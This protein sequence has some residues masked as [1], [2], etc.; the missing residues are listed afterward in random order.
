M[1]HKLR[2]AEQRDESAEERRSVSKSP[3]SGIS[4]SRL[5]EE[6][7]RVEELLTRKITNAVE[8]LGTLMKR[9]VKEQ[10]R[11]VEKVDTMDSTMTTI[12]I[13]KKSKETTLK[14]IDQRKPKSIKSSKVGTESSGPKRRAETVQKS[15]ETLMR[16]MPSEQSEE[17]NNFSSMENEDEEEKEVN[18]SP[19]I[20]LFDT[21]SPY[22]KEKQRLSRESIQEERQDASLEEIRSSFQ[23]KKTK[24]AKGEKSTPPP[25]RR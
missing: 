4:A 25:H 6:L 18:Y 14:T 22:L 5:K 15:R 23:N 8:K 13:G 20:E 24:K 12:P 11:L 21:R 17:M 7:K 1:L 9:Y 10:K 19:S 2:R 16:R 3:A